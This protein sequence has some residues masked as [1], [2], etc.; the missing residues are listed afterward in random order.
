MCYGTAHPGSGESRYE[1]KDLAGPLGEEFWGLRVAR[2]A[3]NP[4]S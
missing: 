4:A 1:R 2:S 3:A